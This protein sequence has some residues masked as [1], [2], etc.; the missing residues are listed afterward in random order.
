M[1]QG[2]CV[3]PRVW[4]RY[5]AV[6]RKL[7]QWRWCRLSVYQPYGRDITAQSLVKSMLEDRYQG[8]L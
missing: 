3:R 2:A 1:Q 5:V 7:E 8:G 4:M 6:T